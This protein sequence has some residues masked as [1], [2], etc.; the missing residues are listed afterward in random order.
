MKIHSIHSLILSAAALT[1]GSTAFA[2]EKLV[3]HV[4]F[5]FIMSGS[6]MPAGDYTIQNPAAKTGGYVLL[7]TNTAETKVRRMQM[8]VADEYGNPGAARLIF[9]CRNTGCTLAEAWDD[10]GRGIIFR[11]PKSKGA[12]KERLAVVPVKHTS[13]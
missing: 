5:G 1:F 7:L 6:E 13:E 8:G 12:E 3:A 4:P 10:Q 2:Q 11:A 9:D